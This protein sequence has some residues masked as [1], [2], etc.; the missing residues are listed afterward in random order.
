MKESERHRE[1]ERDTGWLKG[2]K[3]KV[4][5]KIAGD[6]APRREMQPSRNGER[7]VAGQRYQDRRYERRENPRGKRDFGAVI[8]DR[9]PRAGTRRVRTV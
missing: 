6:R 3:T 4:E 9:E 8:W 5:V 2:E 1:T 7:L